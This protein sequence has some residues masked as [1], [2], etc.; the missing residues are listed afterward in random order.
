[1]KCPKCQAE[2][3]E[4]KKFCGECGAPLGLPSDPTESF[5]RTLETP[6][7]GLTSGTTFAGRYQIIEELGEGGMGRVYKVLDTEIETRI[8]LKI[9]KPEVAADQKTIERFRNELKTAR[10]ITHKNVCRMYHLG[11]HE[12]NHYITMEFVDGEDLKGTIKRV[13]PVGAGKAVAIARQVCE[14][15]AEAH[16]AGVIHRDL[17]PNNIMIDKEGNVRIMDF[18]IA[19]SMEAKG[20]TGAGVM[21]GTPEYMSPEQ[22][23]AKDLDPRSDIY[24]LGVILFEMLTGQLPFSGETP[25]SI[26]LKHVKDLPADPRTLNPQIPEDLNQLILKCLEKDGQDRYQSA[27]ELLD[28][29]MGLEKRISTT[30]GELAKAKTIPSKRSAVS[31]CL[32][33]R[34]L[35]VL[36]V[37]ILVAMGLFLWR[38]WTTREV[39]P[40]IPS[41]LS[42]AVLPFDDLSP[43]KDQEY[44]CDGMTD[45]L[46]SNLSRIPGL[47]V[48]ARTSV[49]QYKETA[50]DIRQISQE[51]GTEYLLEG[52]IRKSEEQLRVA[53]SL[54]QAD[55]GTIIWS[56]DYDSEWKDIIDIQDEVSRSIASA[57]EIALTDQTADA[58]KSSSPSNAEAY[59]YYLQARHYV[60]NT[61]V[62]TKK[63]EDFEYALELAEKAV[64]LD[65]GSAIGYMGLAYLYENHWLVTNN[66]QDVEKERLYIQKA[67][68][69]NPRLSDANAALGLMKTREGKYDEA[70]SYIK[71]AIEINPNSFTALHI[72]GMFY[73]YVGLYNRSIEFYSRA[74]EFDPLNFYTQMNRGASLLMVGETDRALEDV[75]KSNQIM[76]DNTY[77]LDTYA[78]VLLLRKEYD[79]AGEVFKRIESLPRG[80]SFYTSLAKALYSA[81]TGETEEA[82]EESR[83]GVVL[84]LLGLKNEAID[85]IESSLRDDAEFSGNFYSYLP[86]T[87]LDV[88]DSLRDDPRFQ[89]I[90]KKE[91]EKYE[92]KL[93]KYSIN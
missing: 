37:I 49:M 45:Q 17:K 83:N 65:P 16:R 64:E 57:L 81:G 46:I 3:P 56:N 8:A 38:P 15:L 29:L 54:I 59:N 14:G 36:A 71:A 48:I 61:Y 73:Q 27:E 66:D 80:Y 19:R 23:E 22:A 70:F 68:E 9:I 43:Q 42:I 89:Q 85:V 2:N 58:I 25:L 41:S 63:E 62:L 4:T 88:Y 1:M 39:V 77:N 18:G 12:D 51:L 69:L 74:L 31:S 21:I 33:K 90:V 55:E 30:T 47:K 6:L 24:S 11:K 52:N 87:K 78:L 79:K 13:G 40:S 5:T 84:A 75:E 91:K 82:L 20:I 67:Y 86:L 72:G 10:D 53:A 60:M 34:L 32:R 93:K 26:A 28:E 92:A 35:P 44:V 76:P 50:K 7:S